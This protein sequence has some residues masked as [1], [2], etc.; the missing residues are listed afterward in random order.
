M[1]IKKISCLAISVIGLTGCLNNNSQPLKTEPLSKLKNMSVFTNN[2][3]KKSLMNSICG[4]KG[5]DYLYIQQSSSDS[6]YNKI[7]HV[8]EEFGLRAKIICKN[9]AVVDVSNNADWS[10]SDQNIFTVTNQI[11]ETSSKGYFKSKSVGEASLNVVFD[12]YSYSGKINV[13]KANVVSVTLDIGRENN[14]IAK[15]ETIPVIAHANY[16]DGTSEIIS[17]P[18]LF[19]N[20]KT[21]QIVNQNIYAVESGSY[22]VIVSYNNMNGLLIG[23]VLPAK[24]VGLKIIDDNIKIFTTGIP[25][26]EKVNAKLILSDGNLIDIPSSTLNNQNKVSC[27]LYAIP[28]DKKIPFINNGNDCIIS[29]TKDSG[30]NRLTYKYY[31]L[32]KYGKID[33]TKQSFEDSV[34]LKSTTDAISNIQIS[35]ESSLSSRQRMIV[36]DVYRYHIYAYLKNNPT[37]IDLTKV[38]N[39][40][41]N[42][43]YLNTDYSNKLV[44]GN[45]GYIGTNDGIDDGKGGVIKLVDYLSINDISQ[46]KA[47]LSFSTSLSD[48]KASLNFNVDIVPSVITAKE[49]SN[50]FLQN[51]YSFLNNTTKDKVITYSGIDKYGNI[52]N[53]DNYNYIFKSNPN[54]VKV[55]NMNNSSTIEYKSD[56]E[57]REVVPD[58]D[59]PRVKDI[60]FSDDSSYNLLTI[61]CNNS[62]MNQNATTLSASTSI[63]ET[64][65]FGRGFSIGTEVAAETKLGLGIGS[66]KTTI[67]VS[68]GYNQSWSWAEA[69]AKTI[70]LPSQS[71]LLPPKNKALVI[72]RLAKSNLS[73]TGVFYLPLTVS[74]CIP[75]YQGISID[76]VS[77]IANS[78]AYISDLLNDP[79]IKSDPLFKIFENKENVRYAVNVAKQG[80][81]DIKTSVISTYVFKPTDP[82]Y[83]DLKC[84]N[85]SNLHYKN[86][87]L[88]L[89]NGAVVPLNQNNLTSVITMH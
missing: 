55:S 65:T 2:I 48:I 40:N 49:L 85:A 32:D 20:D 37:P 46:K 87:Q 58:I 14:D 22:K 84:N 52:T 83:E 59:I 17:N 63:T 76:G 36:G 78:C 11:S 72:Q 89:S 88:V 81:S 50:Y 45:T 23:N 4:I 80:V 25:R 18:K 1:S 74:S 12:K 67:K 53:I 28:T 31:Y 42:L 24:V 86:N 54:I 73:Y 7:A 27:T 79:K 35:I 38:I 34:I 26:T 16:A 29:S 62:D 68:G 5:V 56:T 39:L 77:L 33:E 82:G 66:S 15:G 51:I 41:A 64:S 75:F 70:T 21:V 43:T 47:T 10:S 61:A 44:S 19:T 71:V 30:E 3:D 57:E 13:L 8:G 69:M 60:Q 9:K 6:E